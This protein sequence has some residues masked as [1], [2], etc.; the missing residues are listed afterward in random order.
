MRGARDLAIVRVFSFVAFMWLG[1]KPT[2][3]TALWRNNF[4]ITW[5]QCRGQSLKL[6]QRT[7][8]TGR[9]RERVC[10]ETGP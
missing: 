4:N 3:S 1:M 10:T 6:Y 7:K 8:R 5:R 9:R 2:I